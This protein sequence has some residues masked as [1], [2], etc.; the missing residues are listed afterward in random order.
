MERKKSMYLH[1]K[2]VYYESTGAFGT[3]VVDTFGHRH[4]VFVQGLRLR[5]CL[6][7]EPRKPSVGQ[8]DC[9][10]CDWTAAPVYQCGGSCEMR[11]SKAGCE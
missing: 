3:F 2:E 5:D 1:D 10:N 7:A 8:F 9:P 6:G 4:C 11:F